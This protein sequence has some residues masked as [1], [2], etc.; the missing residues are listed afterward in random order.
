MQASSLMSWGR[1]FQAFG[2]DMPKAL[3]SYFSLDR[4]VNSSASVADRRV[5][6]RGHA[7]IGCSKDAM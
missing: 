1:Q 2:A 5:I 7:V 3:S 4:G 6:E